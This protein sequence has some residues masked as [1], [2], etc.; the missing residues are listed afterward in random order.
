[1][2]REHMLDARRRTGTGIVKEEKPYPQNPKQVPE[3][4]KQEGWV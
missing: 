1:M 4:R 3:E 2:L